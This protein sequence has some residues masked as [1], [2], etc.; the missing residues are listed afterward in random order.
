ML[1]TQLD[2]RGCVVVDD[3]LNP[4]GLPEI[5]VLG[6]LAHLDLDL[7]HVDARGKA[8]YRGS[9]AAGMAGPD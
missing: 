7:F 9:K 4:P 3:R 1:G 8:D 6:D 5:S 2:H